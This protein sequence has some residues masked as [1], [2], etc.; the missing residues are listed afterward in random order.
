MEEL[1]SLPL[2]LAGSGFVSVLFG[3]TL[4]YL[5]GLFGGEA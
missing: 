5:E 2:V 4:V 1:F 3:A